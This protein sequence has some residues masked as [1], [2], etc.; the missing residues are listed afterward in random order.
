MEE[1]KGNNSTSF[2]MVGMG[3]IQ[4]NATCDPTKSPMVT[5]FKVGRWKR[6]RMEWFVGWRERHMRRGQNGAEQAD[7]NG[8]L[9]T[10]V[11]RDAWV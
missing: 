2:L 10:H 11:Q 4:P 8:E 9:A 3:S 6:G 1:R 7:V 5:E